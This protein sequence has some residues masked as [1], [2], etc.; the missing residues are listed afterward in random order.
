M[1]S[2]LLKKHF[3][4]DH[5]FREY[6]GL[7]HGS[8]PEVSLDKS[9]EVFENLETPSSGTFISFLSDGALCNHGNLFITCKLL[10]CLLPDVDKPEFICDFYVSLNLS[11]ELKD[12]SEFL[13]KVLPGT[14]SKN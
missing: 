8:C 10:F 7:G 12:A 2:D 13:I 14:F 9:L 6:A 4:S 5:N 11:Q 3:C 1:T